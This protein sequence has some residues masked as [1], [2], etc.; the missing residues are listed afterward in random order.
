[1]KI[2]I[3]KYLVFFLAIGAVFVFAQGCA[4]T[5]SAEVGNPVVMTDDNAKR[6]TWYLETEKAL[7]SEMKGEEYALQDIKK[8]EN[9][10]DFQLRN[11]IQAQNGFQANARTI[12]VANDILRELTSLI[13]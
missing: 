12:R 13:R 11:M 2:K 3:A 5:R 6:F 10:I 8:I 4:T 9:S 1:M 7:K